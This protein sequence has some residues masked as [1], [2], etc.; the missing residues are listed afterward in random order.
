QVRQRPAKDHHRP[1]EPPT[2]VTADREPDI[3]SMLKQGCVEPH[4]DSLAFAHDPEGSECQGHERQ[5]HRPPRETV[6]HFM[7]GHE[8]EETQGPEATQQEANSQ[9]IPYTHREGLPNHEKYE[10]EADH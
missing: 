3:D 2:A 4:S 1:P 7:R 6:S 8:Q 5:V 9:A 10:R